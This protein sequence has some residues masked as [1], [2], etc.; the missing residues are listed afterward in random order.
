MQPTDEFEELRTEDGLGDQDAGRSE[1]EI[2]TATHTNTPGGAAAG[3]MVNPSSTP[4]GS[5]IDRHDRAPDRD[6]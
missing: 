4:P 3:G 2:I 6:A 1:E 5:V